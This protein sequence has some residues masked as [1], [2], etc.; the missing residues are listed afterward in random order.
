MNWLRQHTIFSYFWI[1]MALHILNCSIDAPDARPDYIAEDLS[2]NDIESISELVLEQILG[3]DN[4]VAEHDEHDNEEGLSFE[5]AKLVLYFQ[6]NY[7]FLPIKTVFQY[8][9]RL[10]KLPYRNVCFL[11]FQPDIVSPPPQLG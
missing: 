1:L 5:I 9:S 10:V 11:Q 4:A 2:Y 3:F 7:I 8:E 6:V